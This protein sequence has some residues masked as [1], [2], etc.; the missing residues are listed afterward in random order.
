MPEPSHHTSTRLYI[1]QQVCSYV[2]KKCDTVGQTFGVGK[3]THENTLW[4]RNFVSCYLFSCVFSLGSFLVFMII[5][6]LNHNVVV[7]MMKRCQKIDKS[8][9]CWN[10]AVSYSMGPFASRQLSYTWHLL[11]VAPYRHSRPPITYCIL[12]IK[13]EVITKSIH[14]NRRFGGKISK[15]LDYVVYMVETG[16]SFIFP[17]KLECDHTKMDNNNLLQG[18][19][20]YSLGGQT[21]F[22][23]S[24]FF[25]PLT[26]MKHNSQPLTPGKI[27][28]PLFHV[29]HVWRY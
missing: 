15:I 25:L 13:Y 2:V 19:W 14:S 16:S 4:L 24:I 22:V 7:S 9:C 3:R 8:G 23:D 5:L 6:K 20:R 17:K 26:N 29:E 11:K 10:G 27:K 18:R 21:R 1:V 12:P 28:N